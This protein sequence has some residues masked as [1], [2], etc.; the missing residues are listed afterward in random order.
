MASYLICT[1][2]LLGMIEACLCAPTGQF[3]EINDVTMVSC[4]GISGDV[5]CL[6]SDGS[7]NWYRRSSSSWSVLSGSA[8]L[9]GA[10]GTNLYAVGNPDN[11]HVYEYN[12]IYQNWTGIVYSTVGPTNITSF[13][14]GGNQIIISDTN[15][16]YRIYQGNNNWQLLG[17]FPANVKMC[18]AAGL[19]I[20]CVD[21]YL[22]L[23]IY[24]YWASCNCYEFSQSYFDN[25]L[26]WTSAAVAYGGSTVYA[27]NS[28]AL[29]YNNLQ[30]LNFTSGHWSNLLS[31][32]ASNSIVYTSTEDGLFG[33]WL[34]AT[35]T[36]AQGIAKFD[37]TYWYPL[38]VSQGSN[39]IYGPA[40]AQSPTTFIGTAV[41]LVVS[42]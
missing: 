20:A 21:R 12:T 18:S 42:S 1:L 11:N 5:Y 32:A 36:P 31:P 3:V 8:K 17:D 7:I 2:V 16:H 27:V 15:A 6:K 19:V 14:E 35:G 39:V 13:V 23:H 37:G 28:S 33:T 4:S 25:A 22:N 10:A 40:T 38:T 29:P 34:N 30:Q 41:G 26:I 9:I 24:A